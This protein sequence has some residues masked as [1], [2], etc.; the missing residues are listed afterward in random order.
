MTRKTTATSL[1]IVALISAGSFA[2]AFSQETPVDPVEAVAQQEQAVDR[3]EVSQGEQM[4]YPA[5]INDTAPEGL[6]F[7]NIFLVEP[8]GT[9]TYS[10]ETVEGITFTAKGQLVYVS[11]SPTAALGEHEYVQYATEL[12]DEN[13]YFRGYSGGLIQP[14]VHPQ[15]LPEEPVVPT[16]P[17]E[18]EPPTATVEPTPAPTVSPEPAPAPTEVPLEPAEEPAPSETVVSPVLSDVGAGEQPALEPEVLTVDT[19]A[20][21]SDVAEVEE[22]SETTSSTPG[23]TQ[24]VNAEPVGSFAPTSAPEKTLASAPASQ[25][26]VGSPQ[27][28]SRVELAN[29]GFE[30]AGLA[31]LGVALV[32]SGVALVS[33]KK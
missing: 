10:L 4:V 17:V 12:F 21:E 20:V 16:P 23:E 11:V 27:S 19:P 3:L 13:G 22:F 28:G 25:K 15:L 2:P 5:L 29:T 8:D 6:V 33:R 30:E 18:E 7:G 31:L 14:I 24:V 32:G 26:Q 1:A 9:P